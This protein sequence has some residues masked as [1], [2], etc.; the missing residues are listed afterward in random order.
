MKNNEKLKLHAD[1]IVYIILRILVILVMIVQFFHG[2]YNNVFM[3]VLTLVLFMIPSIADHKLNIKLPTTLEI[4]ILLFIFAAEILGEI[5]SF[6]VKIPHW[7][8]MLHTINGFMMAAIGFAMIDILNQ[9]PRF[10]INMSPAFVAFVAFCFSMTIGVLWEFFEFSMDYFFLTDMQKDTMYHSISSVLLNPNGV[11]TPIIIKDITS[12]VINSA[13]GQTIVEGG[14]IDI[15]VYDTVKDMMVNCLG[16]AIFSV[17]GGIYIKNREKGTFAARFIPRLKTPEE[18]ERSNQ[19]RQA[20]ISRH[21]TKK[22][23][24]K[25]RRSRKK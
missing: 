8:T 11:N 15:G 25:Q 1:A 14:Y 24:K 5:H 6:Y 21:Q 18:I 20:I 22:A 10:H 9:D 17:I 23:Q 2:N 7:D 4:V 3:C 12:T 13:S 16:A 19:I